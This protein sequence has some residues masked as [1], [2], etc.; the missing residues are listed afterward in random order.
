MEQF[1]SQDGVPE[2]FSP[3]DWMTDM[4]TFPPDSPLLLGPEDLIAVPAIAALD[5]Q[6]KEQRID[7][8]A[9][10]GEASDPGTPSI[11]RPEPT[12]RDG[13][14]EESEAPEQVASSTPEETSPPKSKRGKRLPKSAVEVLNAWYHAHTDNPYPT[15]EEK[16]RLRTQADLSAAQ[17]SNW[18]ANARRRKSRPRRRK[19]ESEMPGWSAMTPFDRWKHSP[20]EAEAVPVAAIA[21][22]VASSTPHLSHPRFDKFPRYAGS[23]VSEISFAR[24]AIASSVSSSS[25]PSSDGSSSSAASIHSTGSFNRF[26]SGL[27]HRRRR[28]RLLGVTPASKRAMDTGERPY[29]C[30]FCTDRFKTRYDWVRHEK[31][32]HLSLEKWTCMPSGPIF[33]DEQRQKTQ[34]ALCGLEDPPEGHA[35]THRI[36]EC[37]EKPSVARTFYRKDHLVQHLRLVHGV[38][39]MIPSMQH[40][41]SDINRVK[42]RCGFCNE[43]FTAWSD[44]NQHLAEHFKNGA[45][46]KDWKGCRGLDPAFAA[47]VENAMPPYIIAEEA[48]AVHP[49]GAER[50]AAYGAAACSAKYPYQASS[51][52]PSADDV[53]PTPFAILTARLGG[54]VKRA[55]QEGIILT[56]EM[57]QRE[58]RRIVYDDDDP[59]NQT[60]AD[61]VDWLSM[62]KMG[63]GLIDD[64]ESVNGICSDQLMHIEECCGL[65]DMTWPE[66]DLIPFLSTDLDPLA[67]LGPISM[68]PLDDTDPGPGMW[69]GSQNRIQWALQNP[70][71]LAEYM[72]RCRALRMKAS[73]ANT[74]PIQSDQGQL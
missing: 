66:G 23:Q 40:W 26:H 8:A 2:L 63:H 20:P 19:V 56:D 18:M 65:I 17:I 68:S 45:E 74:G 38:N 12:L 46:M 14:T 52:Q 61:N 44:R 50:I 29:Q 5:M 67:I 35:Y 47:M 49:F 28:T 48:A 59:W 53:R 6:E 39:N 69:T 37:T 11:R 7:T 58:A 43:R 25:A 73:M 62:F 64:S 21:K 31:T 36:R 4:V 33:Y 16:D 42:A 34:C 22:A 32:L 13:S 24:S 30:T 10:R 71:C 60:A 70:E 54:Y 1:Q 9:F 3:C 72:G 55:Q 15:E 57:L 41:R 51:E 27:R